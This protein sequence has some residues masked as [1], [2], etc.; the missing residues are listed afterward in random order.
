MPIDKKQYKPLI[1]NVRKSGLVEAARY[2]LWL[3]DDHIAHVQ[4][5]EFSESL[6]RFYL[7]DI[8]ALVITKT[9][10]ARIISAVF[11]ILAVPFLLLALLGVFMWQ[12]GS[13]GVILTLGIGFFFIA[14]LLLNIYKGPTCKTRLHTAVQVED[15]PGLRRMKQA[16]KISDTLRPLIE[17][18]QGRLSDELLH[19][20]NEQKGLAEQPQPETSVA[21]SAHSTP[22]PMQFSQ[23]QPARHE[24][25]K[26]HMALFIALLFQSLSS[27][28]DMTWQNHYKNQM[29]GLL[30]AVI[31]I[32]A[33]VALIKQ[34]QS[35][36]PGILKALPIVIVG[37][38]L[39]NVFA[40]GVLAAVYMLS[41]PEILT[42]ARAGDIKLM[43]PQFVVYFA[44]NAAVWAVLGLL[45]IKRLV[46]FRREYEARKNRPVQQ[47]VPRA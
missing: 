39:I 7:S 22:Y 15:L 41:D 33:I 26:Y 42:N 38:H 34:R 4:Q 43:G 46:E 14:L 18:K 17:E 2:D 19:D 37:L 47:A 1:K 40:A 24:H 20:E 30:F 27:A 28:I 29:D 10:T 6:K 21:A 36:M 16:L 25:G 12:W 44:V 8:Q 23:E 32:L 9:G 3:G 31:V 5:S 11:I 45:G 13:P 35:D